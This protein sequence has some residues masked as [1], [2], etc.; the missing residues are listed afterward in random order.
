MENIYDIIVVGGGPAGLTAAMTAASEGFSVIL[1]DTK[2]NI[3]RQTRPCC[4]MWILEPGFHNE[5]WTFKD[6]K[7]YFHRNDFSIPYS[8][9]TVDLQRSVRISSQGK[10]MV[11]GKR[12]MP[13]AKVIDKHNLLS[14]LME[15]T[16]KAGVQIRKKTT[17]LGIDES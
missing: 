6:E 3:T 17:C 14:G 7:I 1:V 2:L 13:I 11:M 15:E 4:S 5:A 16:E 8:G 10:T 9:E 12:L